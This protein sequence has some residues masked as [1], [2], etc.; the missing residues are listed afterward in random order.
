[1]FCVVLELLKRLLPFVTEENKPPDGR[2][3][4]GLSK[5]EKMFYG[6]WIRI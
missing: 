4:Y 2:L 6:F 5:L 1:M 3:G